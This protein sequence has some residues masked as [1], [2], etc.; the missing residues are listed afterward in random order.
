[1]IDPKLTKARM[2][3]KIVSK[4]GQREEVT[5]LGTLSSSFKFLTVGKALECLLFLIR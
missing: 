3:V 1:M 2:Q 4:D 5:V